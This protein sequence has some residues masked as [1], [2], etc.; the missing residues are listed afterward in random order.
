M[1]KSTRREQEKKIYSIFTH[2]LRAKIIEL[3]GTRGPLGFTELKAE[4]KVGV[5]TL[6]YHISVLGE[7][8]VQG[9]DKRYGLSET[10]RMAYQL[11]VKGP[12]AR[13][14]REPARS[15]GVAPFISGS[16][17]F[18]FLNQSPKYHVT[19]T[20]AIVILGAWVSMVAGLRPG[21]L[22][23]FESNE[24]QVQNFASFLVGWLVVLFLAMGIATAA[25]GKRG[26][27]LGLIATSAF[28]YLPIVVFAAIW[29]FSKSLPQDVVQV[30]D[31]WLIRVLFFGLQGWSLILLASALRVSKGLS[32]TESALTVLAIAYVNAVF[33][34]MGGRI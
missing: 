27:N 3:L 20:L 5:G 34:I 17:V 31:G 1:D 26:G 13:M 9:R 22:F 33:V 25:F 16:F 8:I 19:W 29:L 15:G 7:L 24:P 12:G 2:P 32:T 10:G 6:Y 23:L 11:L 30:F 18:H 4:T 14:E 21:I 28:S